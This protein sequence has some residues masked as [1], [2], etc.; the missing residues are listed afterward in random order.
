MQLSKL[1]P[2]PTFELLT[3]EEAPNLTDL[4]LPAN[5]NNCI[6]VQQKA[7]DPAHYT[8]E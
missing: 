3:G 4:R 1:I 2:A 6:R 5:I 8:V 7:Y